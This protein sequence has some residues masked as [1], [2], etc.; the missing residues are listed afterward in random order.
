MPGA[1]FTLSAIT[2]GRP[3]SGASSAESKPVR[4][5]LDALDGK[6]AALYLRGVTVAQS[7]RRSRERWLRI[8]R[9]VAEARW[10]CVMAIQ[11]QAQR[12]SDI[13]ARL[14]LQ[15][16]GNARGLWRASSLGSL[17][18]LWGGCATV[19]PISALAACLDAA[20]HRRS[21][22]SPASLRHLLWC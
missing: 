10:C 3:G 15:V 20:I 6:F 5:R 18:S 22:L 13:C 9:F 11:T 21:A 14:R 7:T 4:T 2:V 19:A 8:T 16:M 1:W 17:P 12:A